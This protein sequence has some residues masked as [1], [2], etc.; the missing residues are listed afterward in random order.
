MILLQLLFI[1]Y[2]NDYRGSGGGDSQGEGVV[3]DN[4]RDLVPE[5]KP[6]YQ[7]L[8]DN[9]DFPYMVCGL[10]TSNNIMMLG[11][12]SVLIFFSSC[13]AV[14]LRVSHF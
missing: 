12:L 14:I 4:I 8:I 2:C 9:R 3:Y 13:S 11:S 7:A 6:Y 1:N 10:S 5:T